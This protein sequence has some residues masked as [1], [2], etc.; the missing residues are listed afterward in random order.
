[1]KSTRPRKRTR[2]WV[3]RNGKSYFMEW[4]ENFGPRCT[5]MRGEAKRFTSKRKAMQ[6]PAYSFALMFFDPEAVR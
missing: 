1:M 4:I 6:S 5:P 3:L 2:Y